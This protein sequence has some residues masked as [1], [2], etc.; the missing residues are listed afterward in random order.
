M[1]PAPA[2]AAVVTPP[3]AKAAV[4]A[5]PQRTALEKHLLAEV[6]RREGADLVL[7]SFARRLLAEMQGGGPE[8]P[9]RR[10]PARRG[11]AAR[12]PAQ[13]APAAAAAA[14]P[15]AAAAQGRWEVA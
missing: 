5:A 4:V 6:R 7:F 3:P 13:A 11:E 1:V 2:K 9:R 10:S 12:L 15:A 8:R 14:A